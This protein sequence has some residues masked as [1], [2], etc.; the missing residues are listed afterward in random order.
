MTSTEDLDRLTHVL[1]SAYVKSCPLPDKPKKQVPPWWTRFI[2]ESVKLVRNLKSNVKKI[3][4]SSL[5]ASLLNEEYNSNNRK[6]CYM[7]RK[8]KRSSWR[9]YCNSID[10]KDETSRLR[11]ILSKK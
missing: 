4:K 5:A 8:L 3:S 1:P 9:S 7:I 11:K 10:H 6:L 2:S